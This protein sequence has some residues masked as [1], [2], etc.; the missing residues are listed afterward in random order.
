LAPLGTSGLS[1]GVGMNMDSQTPE[2]ICVFI[3]LEF[4]VVIGL[5][6]TWLYF[7]RQH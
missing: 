1:G 4:V 6:Y 7:C 3:G 5:V 2:T